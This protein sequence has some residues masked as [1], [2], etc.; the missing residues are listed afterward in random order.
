MRATFC[1]RGVTAMSVSMPRRVLLTFAVIL[2]CLGSAQAQGLLERLE[3]RLE[4]VLGDERA[5]PAAAEPERV[6]SGYL[7]LTGDDDE[8]GRGV[9]GLVVRPGGAAEAAGLQVSD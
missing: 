7:G 6:E 8:A 3:K 5:A 4:G 9:K 1:R 2:I